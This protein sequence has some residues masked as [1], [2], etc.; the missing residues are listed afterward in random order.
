MRLNIIDEKKNVFPKET[1]EICI[2]LWYDC[3]V[4]FDTKGRIHHGQV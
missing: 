3:N 1:I 4:N 2:M